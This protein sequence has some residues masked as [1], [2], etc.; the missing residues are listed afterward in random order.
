MQAKK[1]FTK[2]LIKTVNSLIGDGYK[3]EIHCI[4][5]I[6]TGKLHALIILNGENCVSPNF[7]IDGFYKDYR[8]GKATIDEIAKSIVNVYYNNACMQAGGSI[9]KCLD[10]REW[11]EERLFLQLINTGK[12]KG[13]LKDSLYM[14]FK[15]LSLVLYIMAVDNG[16]GLCKIRVTKAMCQKF[17]WNEKETLHYALKNTEKLFP[18]S[19]FPLYELLQKTIGS[20]DITFK[21]I[22]SCESG[23]MVLTNNRGINGAVAAFYPGV[24]KEISEKHGKSLFLLPSSIHEFIIVE[25]NGIYNPKHLE[26]MVREVNCSAVEPE[27]I[28][29]GN[30]YYYG[31][32]SGILSVFNNGSFEEIYSFE[33]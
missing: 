21:D 1:E 22:P 12:N 19:V 2:E 20:T 26:S 28:L 18:Y 17:D 11:V 3:A 14:D 23:M 32:I 4:E 6:N 16:D 31:F 8:D 29:S 7:Y 15:G 24:L 13:L 25:D 30:V 33:D 9:H 5:K 27:E 10:D